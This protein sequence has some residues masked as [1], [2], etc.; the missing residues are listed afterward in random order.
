VVANKLDFEFQGIYWDGQIATRQ[1]CTVLLK[2]DEI[3]IKVQNGDI[4]VWPHNEVQKTRSFK[5]GDPIQLER[6]LVNPEILVVSDPEFLNAVSRIFPS[7]KWTT[8]IQNTVFRRSVAIVALLISFFLILI[9][10]ILLLPSIASFAAF[11]VPVSWEEQYGNS[12]AESIA[13]SARVCNDPN[14]KHDLEKILS[15][16]TD[17]IPNNYYTFHLIV[18][19]KSA[20]NAFAVPGGNIF[21]F[22]GL[23]EQTESPD[24]LAGVFAH[25]IQH[26]VQHHSMREILR[27]SS[28]G[29]L[30]SA[31]TFNSSGILSYG[32]EGANIIGS[33]Q[34]SREFEEEA[35]SKGMDL[36]LKSQVNPEGMIQFFEKLKESEKNSTLPPVYLSTHPA[37]ESRINVLRSIKSQSH[38]QFNNPFKGYNWQ[39]IKTICQT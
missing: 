19:D 9:F 27:R 38:R 23:L 7:Q 1:L 31:L 11:H 8:Y 17:N 6:G 22:S 39:E 36:L 5:K 18:L 35:D 32:M 2:E 16:L 24:E 12:L 37:T 34:F 4:V 10:Y 13:K 30:L 28:T 33:L 21:V 20:I 25:E 14:K 26:V 3:H 15:T 29:L